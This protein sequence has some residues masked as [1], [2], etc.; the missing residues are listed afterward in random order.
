MEECLCF[1]FQI[2]WFGYFVRNE[3]PYWSIGKGRSN[4]DVVP[5]QLFFNSLAGK[6]P[7]Y[8]VF[9]GLM[10]YR[11]RFGKQWKHKVNLQEVLFSV[12][13]NPTKC[14]D[15]VEK[16]WATAHPRMRIRQVEI[17]MSVSFFTFFKF[18]PENLN[19]CKPLSQFECSLVPQVETGVSKCQ[20]KINRFSKV[21]KCCPWF[22]FRSKNV[23]Q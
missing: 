21:L 8:M 19:T 20:Q 18:S 1:P 17:N 11:R 2:L 4:F 5:K 15:F 7:I 12:S 22:L 9:D 6:C 3:T 13:D 10:V 23:M 14:F 16:Y